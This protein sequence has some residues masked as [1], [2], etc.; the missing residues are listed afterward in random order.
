MVWRYQH[1]C[2]HR[3]Q[4]PKGQSPVSIARTTAMVSAPALKISAAKQAKLIEDAQNGKRLGV[5]AYHAQ[6]E[7]QALRPDGSRILNK[8]RK[9]SRPPQQFLAGPRPDIAAA[10]SPTR[11]AE[12]GLPNLSRGWEYTQLDRSLGA[13]ADSPSKRAGHAAVRD[14]T[15]GA[16]HSRQRQR[17]VDDAAG[18]LS[19]AGSGR[20]ARRARLLVERLQVLA[21]PDEDAVAAGGRVR[22]D[23]Q[24]RLQQATQRGDDLQERLR[25][26]PSISARRMHEQGADG[27]LQRNIN[28]QT[29]V[30]DYDTWRRLVG[31]WRVYYPGGL[32]PFKNALVS[33][34]R[35]AADA[36]IAECIRLLDPTSD[37]YVSPDD[38]IEAAM[39]GDYQYL[40]R[41]H[42]HNQPA[43]AGSSD[44]SVAPAAGVVEAA[45]HTALGSEEE[46]EEEEA[47][48]ADEAEE[49][50][51]EDQEAEV[52]DDLEEEDDL[53]EEDDLEEEEEEQQQQQQQQEEQQQQETAQEEEEG[54]EAD[55][56]ELQPRAPKCRRRRFL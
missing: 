19:E 18:A 51:E 45:P 29:G 55:D 1:S 23:L 35:V 52:E 17:T 14:Q 26:E 47:P 12:D 9:A 10:P 28:V 25:T 37:D 15:P 6:Q 49:A 22:K 3:F 8:K 34:D 42:R 40:D 32:R 33:V 41:N 43:T 48:E 53:G 2:T 11:T 5:C 39:D 46:E 56:A 4:L 54:H 13:I 27:L 50:E 36:A 38:Q 7:D 44:S 21:D 24:R 30:Q 20:P 16:R 31:M